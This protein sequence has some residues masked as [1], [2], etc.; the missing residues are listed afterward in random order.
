MLYY[1]RVYSTDK[2]KYSQDEEDWFHSDSDDYDDDDDFSC[3]YMNSN[4]I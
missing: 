2:Y 3:T 4:S 1:Y